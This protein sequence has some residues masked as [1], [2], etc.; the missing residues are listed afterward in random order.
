MSRSTNIDAA[1]R[2]CRSKGP[3]GLT[4]SIVRSCSPSGSLASRSSSLS[5]LSSLSIYLLT[6]T[7]IFIQN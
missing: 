2:D 1:D 7:P 4:T 3:L 6:D 5:T